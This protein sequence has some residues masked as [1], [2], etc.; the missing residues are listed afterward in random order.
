[1]ICSSF[2]DRPSPFSYFFCPQLPPQGE[3]FTIQFAAIPPHSG[4]LLANEIRR[5]QALAKEALDANAP[6]EQLLLERPLFGLDGIDASLVAPVED[7]A[8]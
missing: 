7:R 2:S 4:R 1:M 6:V 5:V 3:G 8:E